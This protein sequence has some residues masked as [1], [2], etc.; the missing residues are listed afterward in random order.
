MLKRRPEQDRVEE[1]D[2]VSAAAP[3]CPEIA[4]ETDLNAQ[5]PVTEDELK[6]IARLLGSELEAILGLPR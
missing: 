2:Q 4:V 6:A 1:V 3:S 5:F